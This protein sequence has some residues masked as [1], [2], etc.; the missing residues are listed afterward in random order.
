LKKIAIVT[1][2]FVLTFFLLLQLLPLTIAQ[3]DEETNN[4]SVSVRLTVHIYDIDEEKKLANVSINV[5]VSNFPYEENSI[6]VWL[7]SAGD[8]TVNCTNNGQT[9]NGWIYSGKSDT[10]VW[11]LEG[12]GELFPFGSY[13]LRFK[14][15]EVTYIGTNCTLINEEHQAIFVDSNFYYL[16]N[17]WKTEDVLLPISNVD[18]LE[19]SFSVQ[20]SDNEFNNA[21][22]RFYVPTIACYC[23]FGSALILDPKRL[24]AERLRIFLSIFFFVP[25]FLITM[26]EFLPYRTSLSFPELLLVNLL[27]TTSVLVVFSMIG[28]HRKLSSEIIINRFENLGSYSKLSER[29][30]DAIGIIIALLLLLVLYGSFFFGKITPPLASIFSYLIIPAYL[31]WI[32]FVDKTILKYRRKPITALIMGILLSISIYAIALILPIL[33]S[34]LVIEIGAF[35]TGFIVGGYVR[36]GDKSAILSCISGILGS[37]FA[38]IIFGIVLGDTLFGSG[39]ATGAISGMISFGTWGYFFGVF[40]LVGG[41]LGARIADSWG[42]IKKSFFEMVR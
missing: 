40:S 37:L 42:N 8:V 35:F 13:S 33:S 3:I 24:L 12:S 38:G 4:D 23:L 19:M 7:R 28:K 14:I 30:S 11:F 6:S 36:S 41:L 2:L 22:L 29:T 27:V 26:Q 32:P 21:L 16:K 25:V 34:L 5:R 31:F 9:V 20:R 15:Q 39:G 18:A 17:L 1:L 10:T